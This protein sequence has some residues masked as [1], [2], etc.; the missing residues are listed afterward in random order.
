MGRVDGCM[1]TGVRPLQGHTHTINSEGVNEERMINTRCIP[2]RHGCNT[3]RERSSHS[4]HLHGGKGTGNSQLD[5]VR[6]TSTFSKSTSDFSVHAF[7]QNTQKF[8]K[9]TV[10]HG[11]CT[12]SSRSG[13]RRQKSQK[14]LK[15]LK[16]HKIIQNAGQ[17]MLT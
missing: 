5:G 17:T 2:F 10:V 16:K 13:G 9:F 4:I 7:T 6:Q 15:N 14:Y 12:V 11:K 1:G 3:T 8:T